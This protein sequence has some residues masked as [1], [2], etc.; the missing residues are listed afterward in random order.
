M[1]AEEDFAGRQIRG[2][3]EN[4]D[5]DY[6]FCP[7]DKELDGIDGLLLVVADG[8]GGYSGG[9]IAS[10]LVTEAFVEHFCLSRGSVEDR[11]ESS[12]RAAERALHAKIVDSDEELAL[13]GSTLIGI[14]WTPNGVQWVSVGDSAIYVYREGQVIR[15]NA[16][17][18]L[19]PLLDEAAERGEISQQ[20]AVTHPDRG[21]LRAALTK[22][23][24]EMFELRDHPYKLRSGDILLAASD[25]LASLDMTK[26]A[27]KVEVNAEK[28]A[29]RIADALLIA[30]NELRKAKQ[31]N[32]TVA[33]IKHTAA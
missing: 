14:V 28:P 3:R 32:A 10:R 11:L 6:G 29:S 2:S 20:E 12:L 19:A 7:L 5:D 31:D 8:M 30:V 4:Q 1:K 23:P 33:V 25:G 27:S 24:L 18:S 21:V 26:L 15:I 9:A 16:D 22:E 17:H 13:M